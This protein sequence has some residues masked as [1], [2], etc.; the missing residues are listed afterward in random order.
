MQGT[1]AEFIRLRH[2]E[3]A[4][5][6]RIIITRNAERVLLY[7]HVAYARARRAIDDNKMCPR[8]KYR[9]E[10]ETVAR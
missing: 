1:R 2:P 10:S 5:Y 3:N 8:A 9:N 6:E 4:F 7:T